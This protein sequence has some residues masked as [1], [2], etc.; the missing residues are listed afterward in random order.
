MTWTTVR[1]GEAGHYCLYFTNPIT[2][3]TKGWQQA[4]NYKPP[5]LSDAVYSLE[6]SLEKWIGGLDEYST[7]THGYI[8]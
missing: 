5:I 2:L 8:A 6:V 4:H 7:N 1:G 3:E